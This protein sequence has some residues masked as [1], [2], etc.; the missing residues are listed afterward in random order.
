MSRYRVLTVG[1][2]H[3]LEPSPSLAFSFSILAGQCTKKLKQER[4][5]KCNP[6]PSRKHNSTP[7]FFCPPFL[8]LPRLW[9]D[10]WG[11]D[12]K[13]GRPHR[14][15]YVFWLGTVPMHTPTNSSITGLATHPPTQAPQACPPT[16]RCPTT[17]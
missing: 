7:F 5:N 17:D 15:H 13:G 10:G 6:T 3:R 2:R 16:L 4:N 14:H 8:S 9:T 12:A 11:E 1:W